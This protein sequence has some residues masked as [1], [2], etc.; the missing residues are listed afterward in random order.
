VV[1]LDP[2]HHDRVPQRRVQQVEVHVPKR[3]AGQLGVAALHFRA[4][5]EVRNTGQL[6]KFRDV[7]EKP[8]EENK[9]RDIDFPGAN[10]GHFPVEHRHRGEA[11]V[12]DI[13]DTRVPPGEYVRAGVG[14]PV[15]L[16]PDQAALDDRNPDAVIDKPPLVVQPLRVDVRAQAARTEPGERLARLGYRVEL[17]QYRDAG[18]L[19]RGALGRRRVK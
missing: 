9:P 13:A 14:R 4:T 6:E 15:L 2:G 11:V 10:P 5:Q 7:L 16:Q 8:M 18:P 17:G 3:V 12:D 19:H 1:T